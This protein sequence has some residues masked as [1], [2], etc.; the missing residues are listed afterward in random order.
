MND[1]MAPHEAAELAAQHLGRAVRLVDHY[2]LGGEGACRVAVDGAPRIFKY[3]SGERASE[4]RL[5]AAVAAH[6]VLRGCGW[7]LPTIHFWHG[8]TSFA[9]VVEAQMSGHR[10]DSV[11]V[12]LCRRLLGLLDAVPRGAVGSGMAPDAWLSLL[13]RSLYHD[14]PASPL[15]PLALQRTAVGRRVVAQAR[16]AFTAARPALAAARDV[17]H[18]D[19]SAGNILCHDAGELAAMLDWQHGGA[20]HHGFDLAGF[21]WDLALRLNVGSAP[22]L[23][24][25]TARVDALVEE[26]VREFCRAYYCVW[27]LSW[28]F[29]TPD[30]E[31]VLRAAEAVGIPC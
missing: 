27:N 2:E 17:I 8:D 7:P 3:W 31:D 19:F 30:E 11:P 20:G 5:G 15:R 23:A 10:V 21:E 18:G 22:S 9:F 4:M 28:A 1:H 25:V 14:L 13:E 29:D 16:T 26:P 24:L 12:A 6:G